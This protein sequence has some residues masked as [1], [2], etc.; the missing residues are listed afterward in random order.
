MYSGVVLRLGLMLSS[1]L[2]TDLALVQDSYAMWDW[3]QHQQLAECRSQP[4]HCTRGSSRLLAAET[5]LTPRSQ[6]Q[7]WHPLTDSAPHASLCLPLP[8]EIQ[9]GPA[10][11]GQM[12]QGWA[13]LG[14]WWGGYRLQARGSHVLVGKCASCSAQ[15]WA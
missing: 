6:W 7:K 5:W 11:Q 3:D 14:L 9:L 1:L 10:Y 15:Y 4:S 12:L 13:L 8:A 2:V